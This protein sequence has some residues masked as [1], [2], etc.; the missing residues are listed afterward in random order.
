MMDASI[1]LRMDDEELADQTRAIELAL[2]FVGA[3]PGGSFLAALIGQWSR[4]QALRA[5]TM[6]ND[7][8]GQLA[9]QEN[10]L[11]KRLQ[12]DPRVARLVWEASSAAT[13]SETN[14]K[15]RALALVASRGILDDAALDEARYLIDVLRQLE[16]IDVRLLLAIE[17]QHLAPE[18]GLNTSAALG[19]T[20][21]V[22]E[23]INAKLL[24]LAIVEAP[25]MS[26]RGLHAEVRLSPFG[27]EMLNTL[28]SCGQGDPLR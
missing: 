20:P 6:I 13:T 28:R 27:R 22:A 9:N 1:A 3:L 2:G 15:L 21:G 19:V 25:G 23:S 24:Q 17:A 4:V 26:F 10:G 8:L 5:N 12:A 18:T 7:L 14:A 11:V 16:V